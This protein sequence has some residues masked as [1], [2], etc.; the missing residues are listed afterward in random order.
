MTESPYGRVCDGNFV[1]TVYNGSEVET[2]GR[3]AA[4]K[5]THL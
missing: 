3:K 5:A 4:K 1:F 2:F